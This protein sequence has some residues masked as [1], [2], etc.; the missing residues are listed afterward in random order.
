M[1]RERGA[2]ARASRNSQLELLQAVQK[3][4]SLAAAYQ[5]LHGT[6]NDLMSQYND[7]LSKN[8]T[9]SVEDFLKTKAVFS[10]LSGL[11]NTKPVSNVPANASVLQLGK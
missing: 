11:T 6:K 2:N 5:S 4:P 3:D 8:P 7:Y 10:A 1:I 9:G